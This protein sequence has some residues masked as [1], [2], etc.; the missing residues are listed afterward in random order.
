[1]LNVSMRFI[2][3]KTFAIF[4]A[5]LAIG[6]LLVFLQVKGLINP[7]KNIF[8][9][10]PRPVVYVLDKTFYPIKSFFSTVYRL[11][12]IV[13]ENNKLQ[14][15][16][17]A[18]QQQLV[19]YNETKAENAALTKELG[20]VQTSSLQ[21]IPCTVISRNPFGFSD[22]MIINCGSQSGVSAGQGVIS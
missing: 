5:L 1:M 17:F 12:S 16:N 3:T 2:Y 14:Q 4:S 22:S 15:Q 6:V 18:L 13:E 21:I 9:Q 11:N 10:A 7:I 19:D 8:L 20:F